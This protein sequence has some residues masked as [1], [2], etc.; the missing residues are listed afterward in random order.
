MEEATKAFPSLPQRALPGDPYV[1][2]LS[3]MALIVVSMTGG[4]SKELAVSQT[5][6]LRPSPTE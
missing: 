6:R 5:A 4:G 1:F 3:F 2:A